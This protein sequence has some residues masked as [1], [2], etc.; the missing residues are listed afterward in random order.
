MLFRSARALIESSKLRM[1][2]GK[3]CWI[4]VGVHTGDVCAGV[5]GRRM[6]RYCLFGDTVNTASRMESTSVAGRMQISSATY[7]HV[8]TS[9]DLA[10]ERRGEVE[11][12]GKG[13]LVTYFYAGT[14]VE[15][16]RGLDAFK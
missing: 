10:W 5:V 8:A 1:P 13:K 16:V 6:P 4:R 2:N 7:E 3:P 12:K 14:Y 9:A 11:V 15:S